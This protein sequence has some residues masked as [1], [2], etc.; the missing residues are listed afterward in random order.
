MSELVERA[1]IFATAAHGAVGQLRKYTFEPYIVHPAE[2]A[3][4][5]TWS[6]DYTEQ[7]I[8]AAWLHDVI[9]DTKVTKETLIDEFGTEV[10]NLVAWLTNVSVPS[11]GNRK[12]RKQKDLENLAK[13]PAEAQT[14]KIADLIANTPSI[15][16]YDV[17]FAKTYI[18][19]KR[20]LLQVLHKGDTYLWNEAF[21]LLY[22]AETILNLKSK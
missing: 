4:I 13:A 8:A 21:G 2:V 11:D 15:V 12:K 7:M 22:E 6:K 1:R 16:K 5:V 9:E 10:A 20:A 3:K 14:I 18:P 19:E 17:K